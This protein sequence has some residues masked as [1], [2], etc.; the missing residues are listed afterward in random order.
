MF[1]LVFLESSWFPKKKKSILLKE[2]KTKG[3]LWAGFHDSWSLSKSSKSN[4]KKAISD[5]RIMI[6]KLFLCTNK[7]Y[8]AVVLVT[9][10]YL[11]ATS[12][13]FS[14]GIFSS[15]AWRTFFRNTLYFDLRLGLAL[16]RPVISCASVRPW[17]PFTWAITLLWYPISF[18]NCT[19]PYKWCSCKE[20][21]PW[22]VAYV[23]WSCFSTL[24]LQERKRLHSFQCLLEPLN[25]YIISLYLII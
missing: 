6:Q 20:I 7:N 4:I 23:I 21:F 18:Y 9:N 5:K 1:H 12:S 11:S 2:A 22:S 14:S 10:F 15:R 17:F 16:C 25:D 24:S 13:S 8:I 19:T 3:Y